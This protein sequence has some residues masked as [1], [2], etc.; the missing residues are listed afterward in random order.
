MLHTMPP[1]LLVTFVAVLRVLVSEHVSFASLEAMENLY[2]TLLVPVSFLLVFRL[3]RAAVRY[4]DSRAAFGKLIEMCR[5]VAGEAASY[6]G[7]NAEARNDVCRWVVV[8]P[9]ATR[10]YLREEAPDADE[11][12]HLLTGKD[13]EMLSSSKLQPLLCVDRMRRAVL[14]ATRSNRVDAPM[15]V[16]SLAQTLEANIATLTGCMGAMERINNTPLPFAYVAHLRTFLLL[17]LIGIPLVMGGRLGWAAPLITV[18]LAF[19]LLGIEAAAVACERPFGKGSNHLAIDRF[20]CTIADNVSQILWQADALT[21]SSP[22]AD[23]GLNAAQLELGLGAL[24]QSGS[25]RSSMSKPATGCCPTG[26]PIG[27]SRASHAD[28]V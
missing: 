4:Y 23:I 27:R 8:F 18:L 14:R 7:H 22:G 11:L 12:Q 5:T 19:G 10:N 6:L 15:V 21:E 3:N 26:L 17:Y 20:C 24:Q 16:A 1:L 2:S 25:K 28:V 13:F 9:I